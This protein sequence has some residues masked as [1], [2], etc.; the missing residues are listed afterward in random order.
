MS[1]PYSVYPGDK[2]LF[3][4]EK[5]VQ[6]NKKLITMTRLGQ[7]IREMFYFP[8]KVVSEA[9]YF[10]SSLNNKIKPIWAPGGF[11]GSASAFGS[12]H[13]PGVLGSSPTSASPGG[14]CS[15]LCLCLC[16]SLCVSH[17]PINKILKKKLSQLMG[18]KINMKVSFV[19]GSFWLQGITFI[20]PSHKHREEFGRKLAVGSPNSKVGFSQGP[21]C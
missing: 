10:F 2:K 13:D 14:D 19:Y 8:M 9:S 15:S 16:F 11:S 18:G 5:K 4:G 3:Q 1:W 12:G 17:E 21:V 20:K 7:H 6:K